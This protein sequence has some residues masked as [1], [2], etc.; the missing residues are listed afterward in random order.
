VGHVVAEGV[1]ALQLVGTAGA[2][3]PGDVPP[4]TYA[5]R[6]A[7]DGDELEPAGEVTVGPGQ[8]VQLVCRAAFKMC[9]PQ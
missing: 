9:K 6:A 1:S 8:T 5:I 4:G 7:F 2:F 3:P